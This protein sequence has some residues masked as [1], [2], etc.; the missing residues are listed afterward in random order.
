MSE[1]TVEKTHAL[2]EKL[3]EYVMNEV[4]TKREMGSR[5]AQAEAKMNLRFEQVVADIQETNAD[6]KSILNGMDAQAK[7]HEFF[8]IELTAVSRTLDRHE[9]QITAGGAGLDQ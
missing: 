9:K 7:Q 5:F 8:R 2:L 3:S 1:I 6:V 4:P